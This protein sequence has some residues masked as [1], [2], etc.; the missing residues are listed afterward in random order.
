MF[1]TPEL[2]IHKELHDLLFTETDCTPIQLPYVHRKFRRDF[3][4]NRVRCPGCNQGESGSKEGLIDCPYCKGEGYLW[5][6]EIIQGWMFDYS[7]SS[8]SISSPS[9]G[10]YTIEGTKKLVTPSKYFVREKDYVYDI[11][12]DSKNR[13][14]VPIQYDR[15]FICTYSEK[16]TSDGSDSQYN[17]CNL[18]S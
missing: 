6:D 13:I 3:N 12:L 1:Q 17:M 16:Y 7:G 11:V 14:Q 9:V 5:D 18:R 8:R 2:I 10:G 15:K 4:F